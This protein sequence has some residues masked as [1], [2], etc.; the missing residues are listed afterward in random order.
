MGVNGALYL[1]VNK[2]HPKAKPF[3][4]KSGEKVYFIPEPLS[5]SQARVLYKQ[6]RK[7]EKE[8][9]VKDLIE[10]TKEALKVLCLD[11]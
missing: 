11:G 8:K 1:L 6:I 7:S 9:E 2:D 3:K 5:F 4:K 10:N